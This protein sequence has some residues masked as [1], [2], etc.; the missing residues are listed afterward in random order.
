MRPPTSPAAAPDPL[1]IAEFDET[2]VFLHAH[3]R[4]EGWCVL[5]LKEHAEHLSD[6][7]VE[8]QA[9]VFAEVARAAAAVRAA[10]TP[11][12][13]NYECLGN[14]LAHVHWHVIPRYEPPRD[15]QPGETVWVRPGAERD[16]GV[17]PAR[18]AELVERIRRKIRHGS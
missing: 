7:T 4:Y 11:R 15:P 18:A 3:Q 1:L 9:R 14:Q 12:R 2:A 8:R 10:L 13:I 16:C 5:F 17:D 6:L